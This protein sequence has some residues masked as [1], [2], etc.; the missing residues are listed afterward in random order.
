MVIEKEFVPG[1]VHL[2]DLEGK[3]SVCT[4]V[5]VKG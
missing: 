3:A 4:E 1:T 5:R 2:V